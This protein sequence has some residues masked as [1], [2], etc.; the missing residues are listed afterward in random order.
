M[1]VLR[2]AR[3]YENVLLLA[4]KETCEQKRV[5]PEKDTPPSL[6][7]SLGAN[8][9]LNSDR[10]AEGG[11]SGGQPGDRDAVGG[12]GDVIHVDVVAELD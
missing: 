5:F 10:L 11:L 1:R 8:N 7:R 2:Y 9:Y 4:A 6:L 12:A 3:T